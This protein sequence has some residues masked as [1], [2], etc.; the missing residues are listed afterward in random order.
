MP[1]IDLDIPDDAR[2]QLI[3]YVRGKY[4]LDCVG[5]IITFGTF[6]ARAALRDSA[7]ANNIPAS[8]SER[9]LRLLDKVTND[10]LELYYL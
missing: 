9:K 3:E 7:K 5:H 10:T 2:E 1:D 6:A 4:G 8:I